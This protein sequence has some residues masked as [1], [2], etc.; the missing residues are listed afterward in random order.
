[1]FFQSEKGLRERLFGKYIC[2]C[3]FVPFPKFK[4]IVS[5]IDIAAENGVY[6]KRQVQRI[7][8]SL[9][10]QSTQQINYNQSIVLY[11]IYVY[12]IYRRIA[13]D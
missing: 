10:K 7:S 5:W 8:D 3:T 13:A 6:G 11:I 2:A 9:T 4:V 12:C 1:M